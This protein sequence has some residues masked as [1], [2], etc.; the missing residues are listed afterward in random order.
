MIKV[1]NEDKAKPY[2]GDEQF[3]LI[4]SLL[5]RVLNLVRDV[6]TKSQKSLLGLKKNLNVDEEDLERVKEELAKQCEASTFVMEI[7]GQLVLNFGAQVA[8][9]VKSNFLNYFAINL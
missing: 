3:T 9:M 2:L 8:T 5:Q 4:G 1:L 7:S 6:K